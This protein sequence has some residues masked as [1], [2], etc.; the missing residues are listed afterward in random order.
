MLLAPSGGVSQSTY[1]HC[2]FT[3]TQYYIV[4]CCLP[5]W[6]SG[7]L[8]IVDKVSTIGSFL[9]C[10]CHYINVGTLTCQSWR[11]SCGRC[12][13]R[14]LEWTGWERPGLTRLSCWPSEEKLAQNI[15]VQTVKDGWWFIEQHKFV[16]LLLLRCQK[17]I[18]QL[19]A[20]RQVVFL[21]R[22]SSIH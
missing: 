12:G 14:C 17:K 6:R 1:I 2:T 3:Y 4:Q 19:P 5:S 16:V 13:C 8:N 11:P 10:G 7:D 15:W 20:E 9:Q 21:E 22:D 18:I